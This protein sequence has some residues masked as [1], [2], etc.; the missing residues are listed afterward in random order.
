M[1]LCVISTV[2]NMRVLICAFWIRHPQTPTLIIS[3]SLALADALTSAFHMIALLVNSYLTCYNIYAPALFR[4]ITEV[5]RLSGMLITVGHLFLLSCNHYMGILKP[6]HHHTL[7]TTRK[8][9]IMLVL[10]WK[11]PITFIAS[12]FIADPTTEFLGRYV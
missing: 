12:Y 5:L 4:I 11:L 10:L 1:V 3:L 7:V 6:L 9:F 8:V 2:I